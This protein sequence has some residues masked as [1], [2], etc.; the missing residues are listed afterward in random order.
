MGVRIDSSDCT[1]IHC[2][3][4]LNQFFGLVLLFTKYFRYIIIFISVWLCRQENRNSEKRKNAATTSQT[5]NKRSVK[6]CITVQEPPSPSRDTKIP[7]TRTDDG[8]K[9]IHENT[10]T[11]SPNDTPAINVLTEAEQLMFQA[12][13]QLQE[14]YDASCKAKANKITIERAT[15]EKIATTFQQAYEQIKTNS[16]MSTPAPTPEDTSILD[17][18]QQIKARIINLE[19]M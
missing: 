1:Y 17:A 3:I 14:I 15:F 2:Y 13:K 19:A 10:T 12:L 7:P 18:L 16:L 5:A 11:A 4:S 8:K 6:P 9:N